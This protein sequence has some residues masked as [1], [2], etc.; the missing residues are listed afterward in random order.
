M[1][2]ARALTQLQL[3]D[4]EAELH[5]ER[6]R[7][8][9]SI[10]AQEAA[11]RHSQGDYDAGYDLAVGNGVH[12]V[13]LQT[14]T[15]ARLEAIVAAL[16]RLANGTYGICSSCGT[17]ISYGRLVVMPETTLCVACGRS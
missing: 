1:S 12:G 9:R 15:S 14:N 4:L 10:L 7:L 2:T 13:G 6:A 17:H 5:S 11:A 3:R 16:A 8:E